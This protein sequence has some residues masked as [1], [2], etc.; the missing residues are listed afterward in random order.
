MRM[1]HA[2]M[3]TVRIIFAACVLVLIPCTGA[4]AQSAAQSTAS[5]TVRSGVK[6]DWSSLASERSAFSKEKADKRAI[7]ARKQRS[8]KDCQDCQGEEKTTVFILDFY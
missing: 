2:L 4:M 5:V 1:H 6:I 7:L 8:L 3:S